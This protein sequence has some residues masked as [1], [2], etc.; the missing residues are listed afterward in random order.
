[1]IRTILNSVSVNETGTEPVTLAKTKTYLGIASTVHD[2]LLGGLI[3]SARK[4]F[5][6]ES[7]IKVIN[8]TVTAYFDSVNEYTYLPYYP[9]ATVTSVKDEDDTDLTYVL[10]KG[11]N[12]KLKITR[13]AE[14]I[15][16]Y[17]IEPTVTEDIEL[18]IIKKVA[19]DFEFRTGIM[20]NP[21]HVL[22]NNWKATALNYRRTWLM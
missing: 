6:K 14:V 3:V 16:V 7:E 13:D 8:S 2:T 1:M 21:V 19:E 20:T 10:T 17:T 9:V 12:P 5:E 15:V 18:S 22:P 11:D 4:D